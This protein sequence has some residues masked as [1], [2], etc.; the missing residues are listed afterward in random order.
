MDGQTADARNEDRRDDEQVLII[1]EI[2][3]LKHLKTRDSDEA[4]QRQADTAHNAGRDGLQNDHDGLDEGQDDAHKG[5]GGDGRHRSVAGDRHAADR[6]AVGGVGA[7]TEDGTGHRADTV[8]EQG[9]LETG[10]LDEVAVDDGGQVLVVGDVLSEHDQ[11]DR[12]ERNDHLDDTAGIQQS[13]IGVSGEHLGGDVAGGQLLET[14]KEREMRVVDDGGDALEG[15]VRR[16]KVVDNGLEVDDH[17]IVNAGGLTDNGEDGGDRIARDDAEDEGNQTGHRVFLLGRADDDD[18]ERHQTAEQRDE[19][20]R[21]IHCRGV[22]LDDVAHCG[23]RK[24]QTDQCDRRPDDNGRHQLVHPVGANEVDNN[25]DDHVDE[26]GDDR[27]EDDAAVAVG[28]RNTER[29][30]ER[31]GA[32]EEH[33]AVKL[34]EELIDQRA[35]TGA[36]DGGGDLNGQ[37]DDGRHG[38]GRREDRQH[39]LQC[40]DEHLTELGFVV[41][42]VDQFLFHKYPPKRTYKVLGNA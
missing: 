42:V 32:T 34:G 15:A 7:D 13:G 35:D 31:E 18:E 3:V 26:A 20:I 27:A 37:A 16:N 4:V 19:V 14:L 25:R 28:E 23:T 8:A 30:E 39:L 33:G 29:A 21:T 40:E 5:G 6:L 22:R 17:Q 2:E 38:D 9:A 36:E 41:D 10:L 12:Q 1:P 11:R 24:G